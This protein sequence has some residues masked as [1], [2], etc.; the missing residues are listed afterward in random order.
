MKGQNKPIIVKGL[1][2]DIIESNRKGFTKLQNIHSL[3]FL[4]NIENT[5]CVF[6]YPKSAITL[7]KIKINVGMQCS[8][9]AVASIRRQCDNVP[10][11][12]QKIKYLT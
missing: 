1:D 11:I 12:L 6:V 2:V 10:I 5:I 7:K 3:S 9:N 8:I 4:F